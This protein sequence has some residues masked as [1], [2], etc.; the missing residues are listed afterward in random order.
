MFALD[1]R[2]A[3]GRGQA[4]TTALYRRLGGVEVLDQLRGVE[5]LRQ[6]PFVDPARIGV[7][8]WSYGGYMTL[9]LMMQSPG[10]FAAGVAGAPVTDWR[11][12]DT[13]YAERYMGLPEDNAEGYRQ[14]SVLTHA[15]S[16]RDRLLVMHGM[17]D[18]NVLFTHTTLL[19]KELVAAGRLFEVMPYPGSK[20]G[21]LSFSETGIHGWNTIIDFFDRQLLAG[22]R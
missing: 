15:H 22:G 7:L 18:D 20:H 21:A 6:Q 12:Y 9:M 4:F 8:G 19:I 11:L 3:G 16:L 17:A 13:H 14:S 2:G 1:N 10:T 5:W